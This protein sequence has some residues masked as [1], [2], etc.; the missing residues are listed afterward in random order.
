MKKFLAILFSVVFA[1]SAFT[2][3]FAADD[4]AAQTHVCPYCHQEITGDDKAFNDHIRNKCPAVQKSNVYV[5][6]HEGCGARFYNY[7]E[8]R[9]HVDEVCPFKDAQ[10]KDMTLE[11][12]VKDFIMNFDVDGT[13]EKV[14][15]LLTKI[16]LPKIVVQVIGVLEKAVVGLI[17]KIK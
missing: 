4:G 2:A 3:A 14:D 15:K 8:Y 16:N 7:D 10:K 13:L 17:G 9:R 5:C 11:E 1:F 12:K 6:P